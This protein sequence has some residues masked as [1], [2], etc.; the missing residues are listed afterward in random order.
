MPVEPQ[1]LDTLEKL[2]CARIL[3]KYLKGAEEFFVCCCSIKAVSG[4]QVV[5]EIP[6]HIEE[7]LPDTLG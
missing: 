7:H 2:G 4:E 1:G 6:A 5:E 3:D